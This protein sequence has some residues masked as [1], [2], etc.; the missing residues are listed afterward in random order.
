VQDLK[1][2]LFKVQIVFGEP[3]GREKFEGI[4]IVNYTQKGS[5]ANIIIRGDRDAIVE[6]L[7]GMH[8]LLVEVLPLSLEEVFIF[9]MEALGYAFKEVL[10]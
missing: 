5:V 3:F 7:N 6:K 10:K 9:E 1:T 4:E 8:P 2:S